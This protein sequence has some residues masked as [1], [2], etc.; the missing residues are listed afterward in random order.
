MLGWKWAPVVVL[1]NEQ[2][3]AGH[4]LLTSTTPDVSLKDTDTGGDDDDVGEKDH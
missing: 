1:F 4:P 3:W 2:S